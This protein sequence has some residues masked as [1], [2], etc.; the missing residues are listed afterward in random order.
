MTTATFRV[1]T[2]ILQRLGEE[3]ITSF[4]QGIIELVKNSYD[5][6][7]LKCTVEL[8]GTDVPG[9]TVVITDDGGG[10]S[11]NDINEGWLILGRSRKSSRKR[12]SLNR[13]PA[14]SK[15]IGRL[16][17]L[18]MGEE[19]LLVT[20]P[21]E[22]PGTEYSMKILWRD[23]ARNDVIEDVEFDIQR[24]D[25]SLGHGSRIEIR[26]LRDRIAR[27]DV[28]RLA[29]EMIL[30]SDPF[31]DPTGFVPELVVPEFKELEDL[32]RTAYFDDS[33]FRLKAHL[34]EAGNA[35]AKVMDRSGAVRWES[36]TNDFNEFYGAPPA[37]FEL[38]I[39]L[40]GAQSFAGRSST[41]GEVRRWLRQ[42][43]GVHLYHRGLRVR[44]YGDEGHDWLD[45]NLSRSRD[46]EL[47]PSTNTSVGR[48]TVLDEDEELLQKTDR[49]GFV[50]NEVFRELR[51]FSIHALDWMQSVRL[52]EREESK[53]REKQESDQRT[54]RAEAKL[55]Q[56]IGKLP[57]NT[58]PK[59]QQAAHEL[60][61][62][63]TLEGTLLREELGLYKTVASVGTAVSVFAHE[64]EGPATEMTTS[65]KTVKRRARK[66]LGSKYEQSIGRQLDSIER[67]ATLISRFATLPLSLL[68][69][70]KRQ[71]TIVDVNKTLC[72]IVRLFQPYL[73]DARVETKLEFSGA[74]PHVHGSVA[75]IEAILSN[76]I[77]NSVKAFRRKG[78]SLQP[79]RLIVRTEV[80]TDH[81]LVSVLD[82]G[83]GID[84]RL[85]D[86][87]W[88]PG[89]TSDED[90]TGLGLKI[91]RDTAT[92]LGGRASVINRGDL[93]GAV[94]IVELPLRNVT[95]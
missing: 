80:T 13:I 89:I 46:P 58:R 77:T 7:A 88:L 49:T 19:V 10:M 4:D 33:E 9:G 73:R 38:W 51:N 23:F 34:D 1:S 42:V 59:L 70:S 45:M 25:T 64:I 75:A 2:D 22:D 76:L 91:I 69:R 26:G 12:T 95:R 61:T 86:R 79:R 54:K 8:L 74:S 32:V 66:L 90:G 55:T 40:L 5:A 87:I 11:S 85:G 3:L 14:G 17:A 16:G 18:R 36:G 93:G 84:E 41:L 81:V 44:P 78:A 83:P 47:R 53:S 94:F 31:G 6:D 20:R 27:G 21:Y 37:T 24:S 15:G 57:P 62:A 50:E 72:E 56:A 52:K 63:R 67:S 35:S 65:I 48:V 28:L 60:E 82:N 68:K 39:Y 29:R 92:E 43:G 30:L 71:R